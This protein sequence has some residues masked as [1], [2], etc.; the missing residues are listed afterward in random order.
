[1]YR[2]F[3][4]PVDDSDAGIDT[5]AQAVALARSVGARITFAYRADSLALAQQDGARAAAG[6][7]FDDCV[8]EMV[9]VKAEAAARALG[10]P[11]ESM[12]V[13]SPAAQ[14]A[15]TASARGCDLVCVASQAT[16]AS[17][18]PV[19]HC[20]VRRAPAAVRVVAALY[21]L[22]RA[23]AAALCERLAHS[24]LAHNGLAH[25]GLAHSGLAHPGLDPGGLDALRIPRLGS[26]DACR[27]AS[28]L[29]GR[30]S[31]VDAELGELERQHQRGAALFAELER[32]VTAGAANVEEALSGYAQFVWEYFGRKE[33]VIV[34]AA[35][36]YLR[37][38]DWRDLEA[39]FGPGSIEVTSGTP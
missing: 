11:C 26:G 36:R 28:L 18:V 13:A 25:S 10:V 33:G 23:T 38:D 30:T 15:S 32:A 6:R 24:G 5:V 14:L 20:V 22:H 27:L 1:M 29:S 17:D 37:E 3:L 35:Q 31:V 39:A 16:A 34:P 19:L 2:H 12:R 7:R 4:V 8:R 21:R 9:M